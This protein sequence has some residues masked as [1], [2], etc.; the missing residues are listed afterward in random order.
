MSRRAVAGFV[1]C[2]RVLRDRAPAGE[3]GSVV[4][5]RPRTQPSGRLVASGLADTRRRAQALDRRD[6]P[7][8]ASPETAGGLRARGVDR[9]VVYPLFPQYSTAPT[10]SAIEKVFTEEAKLWNTP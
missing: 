7:R 8:G 2:R 9:N 10:C 3:V 4:G 6:I 1:R 5:P